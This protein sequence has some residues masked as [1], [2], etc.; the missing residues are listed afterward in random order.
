[1]EHHFT[2]GIGLELIRVLQIGTQ[3]LVVVDFPIHTEDQVIVIAHQRLCTGIYTKEEE[4]DTIVSVA[5]SNEKCLLLI[6]CTK[7]YPLRQWRDV[8]EQE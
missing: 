7:T 6:F 8:H 2:V 1:M 5:R 3:L 4:K